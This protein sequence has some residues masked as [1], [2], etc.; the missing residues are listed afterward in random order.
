[1]KARAL[2]V[3]TIAV[4]L[5]L[6][7]GSVSWAGGRIGHR[8]VTQ[9]KRI[10]PGIRKGAITGGEFIRISR[11]QGRIQ[12]AKRGGWSDGYLASPERHGLHRVQ[13]SASKHIYQAK[14]NEKVRYAHPRVF[15]RHYGQPY[16]WQ[17]P[18]Y[19]SP[20]RGP[21]YRWRGPRYYGSYFSVIILQP[22]LSIGW[23]VG[24][25]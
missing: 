8:R 25:E 1:M 24:L 17:R 11:E 5:V 9:H 10:A 14:R 7:F 2:I 23:S 4:V 21:I 13:R 12:R 19:W 20:H 16:H 22:G 3:G 18:P 6:V 15:S